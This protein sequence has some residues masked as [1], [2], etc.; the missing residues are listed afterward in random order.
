MVKFYILISVV[1]LEARKSLNVELEKY[2][3]NRF[4]S[5]RA[6]YYELQQKIVS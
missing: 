3:D 2:Y 4:N 5:A 6:Y 1:F